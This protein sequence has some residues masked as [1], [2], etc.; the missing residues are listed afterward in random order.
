MRHETLGQNESRHHEILRETIQQAETVHSQTIDEV[1]NQ[2]HTQNAPVILD[3]QS[4]IAHLSRLSQDLLARLEAAECSG[5]V[6]ALAAEAVSGVL[7]KGRMRKCLAYLLQVILFPN[8][9]APMIQR[10]I[11]C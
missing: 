10:S 4:Q 7:E 3:L 11:K 5:S 1:R 8:H 9:L 6:R 2:S